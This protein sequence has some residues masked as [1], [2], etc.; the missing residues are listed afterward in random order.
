MSSALGVTARPR[1][2]LFGM[3]D[4]MEEVVAPAAVERA[5]VVFEQ[6]IILELVQARKAL[7]EYIFAGGFGNR[8]AQL[9]ATEAS[10]CRLVLR[11]FALT[12]VALQ[13]VFLGCHRVLF[14]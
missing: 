1:E 13:M 14:R 6:S 5:M 8:R 7:T 11:T 4:P 2:P 10:A 9:W 12:L 3:S